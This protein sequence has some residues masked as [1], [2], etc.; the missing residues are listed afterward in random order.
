[1]NS[2]TSNTALCAL[3]GDP[4]EHSFSPLIHNAAFRERGLD[5]VYVAFAVKD[6]EAALK[7]VR[8]LGIRGVSVTIPHKVRALK[9]VDQL[10]PLAEKIGSLNTIV[11]DRGI[12][13]GFNS[14]GMGALK[15]LKERQVETRG[16]RVVLLGSGGASRAIAF[17]L[18]WDAPPQALTI[19][20]VVEDELSTLVRN[21]RTL[22][23]APV[24]G[25]LVDRDR[26]GRV[27][28]QSDILIN[29]SPLGMYPKTTETPVPPELL[30][31]ELV[32]FDVVYNPPRTRLLQD[33][34]AAGCTTISGIEMFVNQAVVQ[35]ELWTGVKAP[36]VVMRKVLLD[37]LSGAQIA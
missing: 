24:E 2:L 18:L 11:N 17:S 9:C 16:K 27:L 30:H 13:R 28:S 15:A 19:L 21:L 29:C 5:Y 1:M 33:A 4:V 25:A 12:L 22:P 3:I 23:G 7:G 34:H 36:E 10:D 32:V 6:L 37:H 14:D 31:P 35:F 8:A 26:L 20:G